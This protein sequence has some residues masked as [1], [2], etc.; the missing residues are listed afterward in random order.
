MRQ[1][2]AGMLW[3]KQFYNYD[4]TRWLDG[5][6]GLPAPPPS[7]L[8]GRNSGWRHAL[9][10]GIIS[11]PDKWEYP[12]YAAWDLAFHC[13]TLAHVDPEFAKEQL[14]LITREWYMNPNGQLPA[15]EWDFGDVN[16]PVHALA[17][18][19]VFRLDGGRDRTGWCRCSTSCCWASPG[20]PMSRTR[21]GD[22]LF[23]GGFLGNGQH[24]AVRPLQATG[25]RTRAR[26]GRR[27]RMD[28]ALLPGH[29]RDRDRAGR[30][31][32]RL[33]GRRGQVLRALRV[34][35]RG[36]Q[37]QGP[38]GR[39]GRLLLRPGPPARRRRRVAD[40]GPLDDGLHPA[41]RGRRSVPE[42]CST[43]CRS[44]QPACVDFLRARPRR[45]TPADRAVGPRRPAADVALVGRRPPAAHARACCD[46]QEF[47]SPHG[48]R[49]SRPAYREH[50]FEFWQDGTWSPRSTTSRPSRPPRCSAATRTGA[51]RS[52]SRS[53]SW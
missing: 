8:T 51:G 24:R 50:P 20:G 30:R 3:S 26:A 53:T 15:Y 11:M 48:V 17:A 44:S 22:H 36:D 6:P 25:R 35:R 1:A 14:R 43:G 32:P 19:A 47:L 38:V 5:D 2:F 27:H 13:V 4:V 39:G 16:P 33:R 28:G 9:H 40:A 18:L 42:G 49:S 34:D 23:G 41:V 10:R 29:A 52:G 31:G 7:R 37:R 46:E 45:S 21:Q 12:W